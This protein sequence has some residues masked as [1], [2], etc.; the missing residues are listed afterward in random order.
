MNSIRPIC[1]A[2]HRAPPFRALQSALL[3]A[4]AR[5]KAVDRAVGEVAGIHHRIVRVEARLSLLTWMTVVQL[6]VTIAVVLVSLTR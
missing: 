4:G 3:E 1:P 5:R 6:A 2:E